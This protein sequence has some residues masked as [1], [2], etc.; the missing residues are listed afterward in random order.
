M[1]KKFIELLT[2][3]FSLTSGAIQPGVPGAC[4]VDLVVLGFKALEMP[5]SDSLME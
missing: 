1:N 2:C 3:P 4:K 5:K